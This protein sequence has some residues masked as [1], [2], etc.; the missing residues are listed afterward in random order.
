MIILCEY[1]FMLLLPIKLGYTYNTSIT[2]R[3][4]LLIK[5]SPKHILLFDGQLSSK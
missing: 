2:I 4:Y 3:V 1:I 5:Q